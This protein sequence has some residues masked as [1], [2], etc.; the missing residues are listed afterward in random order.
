MNYPI[1]SQ[2]TITSFD[3]FFEANGAEATTTSNVY[4]VI[5]QLNF[6][7]AEVVSRSNGVDID[8]YLSSFEHDQEAQ[9]A[10]LAGNKW[11]ADNFYQNEGSIK[12]LRLSRGLSQ[13]DLAILIESQ[14]SHVSRIEKG[15]EDVRASTI[16][17]LA[18]VLEV[19]PAVIL[20]YIG[21]PA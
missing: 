18:K 8:D 16:N 1:E 11:V 19:E 10:I 17:K 7:K 20:G 4:G 14:Q 6:D 21:S 3:K 15:T 12:A 9:A 13:K 5:K 2:Q